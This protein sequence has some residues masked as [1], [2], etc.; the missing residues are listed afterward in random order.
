MGNKSKYID[1]TWHIISHII[2]DGMDNE[3]YLYTFIVHSP[4]YPLRLSCHNQT[5]RDK[6]IISIINDILLANEW[7]NHEVRFVLRKQTSI[8]EFIMHFNQTDFAFVHYL[9]SRYGLIYYFEQQQ[10]YAIW[11]IC[12][13]EIDLPSTQESVL[14]F[15]A[16]TS[17]A[18]NSFSVF[19]VQNEGI[20][21]NNNFA[22]NEYNYLN[23]DTDLIV[24]SQNS[25]NTP[26]LG[27]ISLS[28]QNYLDPASGN[29]IA[30]ILQQQL[31]C[32]RII[33]TAKS[34]YRDLIPGQIITLRNHPHSN[35]NSRYKIL[36]LTHETEQDGIIPYDSMHNNTEYY[37]NL[38]LIADEFNSIPFKYRHQ[39]S[40][41]IPQFQGVMLGKIIADHFKQSAAID[42]YG[43][44]VV[45]LPFSVN[46]KLITILLRMLQTYGGNH[47]DKENY[48]WHFPLTIGAVVLLSFINGNINRPLILGVLPKYL[49]LVLLMQIIINR[50][51]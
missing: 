30:T 12:D 46:L 36:S 29:V 2:A 13:S 4:L 27:V 33:F 34:N 41:T 40:F 9:I 14:N 19:Q 16:Q 6:D 1:T 26:G 17:L 42:E 3:K 23:P 18:V 43:R 38:E 51:A 31:D 48:G 50:I 47:P 10:D 5:Y 49:C 8:I 7:P 25:T 39:T 35:W 24:K 21:S 11:V 15:Q 32:R 28:Y 45:L 22:L 20:L 37:N 44:Y